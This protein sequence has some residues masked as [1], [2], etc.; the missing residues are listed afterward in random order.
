MVVGMIAGIE[1]MVMES[2]VEPIVK[3]FHRTHMNNKAQDHT[4]GLPQ[5]Q[6]ATSLNKITTQVEK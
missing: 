3:E 4:I 6:L 5:G 1:E 2:S